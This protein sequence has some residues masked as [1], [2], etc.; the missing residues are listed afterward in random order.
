LSDVV[1]LQKPFRPVD[2]IRAIE[3]ASASVGRQA[4][5]ARMAG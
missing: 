2:L 3:A 4:G 1:C 5:A